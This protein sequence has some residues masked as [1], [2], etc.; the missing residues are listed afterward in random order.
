M[1]LHVFAHVDT[2]HVALVVKQALRQGLGQLR[3][4]HAG[5]PHEQKR[6]N[7]LIRIL[8]PRLRSDD[9]LR[10]HLHALVLANDPLV[11]LVGQMQRLVTLALVQLRHRNSRPAGNDAGNL[12]VRHGLVHEGH[13]LFPHAFLFLVQLLHKLRETAILQLGGL[14]QV[15]LLLRHLDVLVDLLDFLTDF[16][17]AFHGSLFIVPLCLTPGEILPK[18]GQFLLQMREPLTA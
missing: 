14:V 6:P 1:L 2:Y 8:D 11:Q 12:L 10:H 16:L 5:R 3:L 15:I 17:H 9:G 4:A 18:P 7:R 13:L